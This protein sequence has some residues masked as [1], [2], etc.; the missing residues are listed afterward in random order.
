MKFLKI[1]LAMLSLICLL[2]MPYGFYQLYRF[3]A[4]FTFLFVAYKERSS[5]EWM[6]F[7]ILS[8]IIVQPFFKIA[9]GRI[10]WNIM[11]LIWAII[12]MISAFKKIIINK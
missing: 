2:D 1:G 7:L 4:F 6:F 9:L 8:A 5:E 10:I 3:L 12:L 11:D